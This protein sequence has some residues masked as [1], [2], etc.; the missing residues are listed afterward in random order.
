MSEATASTHQRPFPPPA[1]LDALQSKAWIVGGLGAAASVAGWLID[2]TQFYRSYLVSWILWLSVAAGC[3]AILMLHHLSR[4]AWGVMIRRVLEAAA[5]TLPLL[6]ILFIPIVLGLEEIYVWARPEA[7][8]DE[9]IQHK[10]IYLNP[11]AFVFRSVVYLGIWSLFAYGLSRLSHR[12]DQT[13][14]ETLFRRMQVISA[15]GLGIYCLLT[16]FAAVDWLMSLDPH[17]YSSLFGVYVLGGQ[18][19]AA[20]AFVILAALYLVQREPMSDALNAT[21]FHDYG[22]LLLAFV[23]LWTY[24]A[25]SQLLIIWSA[26]L[27][28]EIAWYLERAHG[29]WKWVSILLVLFHFLLPFLLLLS[30]DLKRNARSLGKV[31]L[32]LLAMR[33]FDLYW[34]AAPSFEHGRFSFHWLDLATLVGLGGIWLALFIGQFKT[35]SLVPVNDPY[36]AEALDNE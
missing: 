32:L 14:D 13:G 6:A 23:M 25:L 33:W 2:P 22:K 15:P 12:Q 8:A 34:L 4:G 7:A 3:L 20:L 19:I 30:R 1:D 26:D 18:G 27:P 35:R 5:R 21:H 24:F 16:T 28:E 11:T 10:A 29:G 9:L 31:A 17:W 36:L